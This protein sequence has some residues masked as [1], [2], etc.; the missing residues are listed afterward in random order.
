VKYFRS[1]SAEASECASREHHLASLLAGS[2]VAARITLM[3]LGRSAEP[4][5]A[6]FTKFL[7][8]I[9]VN[10]VNT[11]TRKNCPDVKFLKTKSKNFWKKIQWSLT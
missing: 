7:K 6:H 9:F 11:S 10:Y 2:A 8:K 3:K 4:R 5:C 1:S